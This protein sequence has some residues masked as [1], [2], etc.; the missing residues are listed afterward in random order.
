MERF[1]HDSLSDTSGV[2][3]ECAGVWRRGMC[4]EGEL[5]G[6]DMVGY[7]RMVVVARL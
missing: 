4:V 7:W 5:E 2:V 6:P 3:E 1:E